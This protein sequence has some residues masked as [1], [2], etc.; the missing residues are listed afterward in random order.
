M[1]KIVIE[2]KEINLSITEKE[3]INFL[4]SKGAKRIDPRLDRKMFEDLSVDA[5]TIGVGMRGSS[6]YI[7]FSITLAERLE[8]KRAI[9]QDFL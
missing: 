6:D 8:I 3:V 2:G 7:W 1:A 9:R 4:E 5:L